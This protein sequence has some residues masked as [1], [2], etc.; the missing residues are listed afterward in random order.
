[1]ALAIIGMLALGIYMSDLKLDPWKLKVYGWHKAT[2][3]LILIFVILRL[4]WR[5]ANKTPELPLNMKAF[6]KLGAH[7]S[8]AFLYIMMLYMPM[9]GWLMSSAAGFPVSVFGWFTL[10]NLMDANKEY[11]KLFKEM[12]EI[13]GFLLI[14]L[15]CLHVSAALFHHFYKKDSVLRRMLPW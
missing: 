8:H 1:M 11:V 13:G 2:G 9:V 3:A 12:H 7:A 6:E 14:G 15:I 10:P 5:F 4:L